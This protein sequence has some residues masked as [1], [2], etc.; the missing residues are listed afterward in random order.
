VAS[1]EA[2]CL[3]AS[4]ILKSCEGAFVG[5][6]TYSAGDA[7]D[8]LTVLLTQVPTLGSMKIEIG[9]IRYLK[10]SKPPGL[11]QL[12]VDRIDVSYLPATPDPWPREAEGLVTRFTGLPGLVWMQIIGPAEIQVVA[13]SLVSL[14]SA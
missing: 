9:S 7:G 14:N 11:D 8:S 1:L 13:D 5:E 3:R 2:E 10:I 4:R 12:F 6:V